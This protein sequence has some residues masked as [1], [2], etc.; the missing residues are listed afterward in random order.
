MNSL[1]SKR[2]WQKGT[3]VEKGMAADGLF[4]LMFELPEYVRHEAGQHYDIRLTAADG[5]VAERSY[6]IGNAP[7]DTGRVEFGIGLL[8]DGE[9]SPY[10]TSIAIGKQIDMRGP[11]GGHFVWSHTM[12]G[13]LI[14]IGGGSGMVPLMA[15]LRHAENHKAEM[16]GRP[17]YAFLSSR[18]F[19]R[20]P[21]Y[22][23]LQKMQAENPDFHLTITLTE[24]APADWTG[25]TSRLNKEILEKEI[26]A[27]KGM[28]PMIYICGPTL[29]VEA[30]A[31]A[32][33]EIGFN[34]HEVRTER[35]G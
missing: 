24:R 6:S 29:F 17:I 35:F 28:M 25:L 23:E 4:R 8:P 16:A 26:G 32:L 13:P 21:Y 18:T 5:Y 1:P 10:L 9:V 19:P 12:P 7:E 27:L 34:A 20:I 3:L 11:I 30:M 31:K 2:N 14:V 22:P 33:L 15:M